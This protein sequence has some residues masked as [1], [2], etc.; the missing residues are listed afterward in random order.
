MPSS[1]TQR[2]L[3]HRLRGVRYGQGQHRQAERAMVGESEASRASAVQF[4][5]S[6]PRQVC[7]ASLNLEGNVSA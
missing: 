5:P 2:A 4:Q 1:A 7:N 3:I 6:A